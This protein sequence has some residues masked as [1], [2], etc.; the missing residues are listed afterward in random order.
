MRAE[1]CAVKED[2]AVVSW[3]DS[4]VVSQIAAKQPE[5]METVQY[6]PVGQRASRCKIYKP[7]KG[8]CSMKQESH[9]ME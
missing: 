8:T 5:V 1:N 4:G 2:A 9:L 3:N 7:G 6:P